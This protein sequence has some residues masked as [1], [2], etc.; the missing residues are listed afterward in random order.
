MSVTLCALTLIQLQLGCISLDFKTLTS[1]EMVKSW[2]ERC[3]SLPTKY[4]ALC[5]RWRM[6][7]FHYIMSHTSESLWTFTSPLLFPLCVHSIR[8]P[9]KSVHIYVWMCSYSGDDV[10]ICTVSFTTWC[11]R[12]IWSHLIH[13]WWMMVLAVSFPLRVIGWIPVTGG[14]SFCEAGRYLHLLS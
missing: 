4:T 8:C 9:I 5:R 14:Y 3:S 12:S 2:G 6:M 7:V 10:S 1:L 13:L 11:L